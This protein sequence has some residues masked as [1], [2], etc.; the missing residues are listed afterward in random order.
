MSLRV[1]AVT[2]I[3]PNR[4]EPL[5]CAFQR[6]Q[7][8]SL[9][10]RCHVEVLATI[11]YLA[12]AS[13]LGDRT[14]PGRLRHVPEQE[15]IDGIPVIHPRVPY[16]PGT[17]RVQAMAPVNAPLYLAGLLPHVRKLRG[18]FDVVLGTFL[19]PDAWAASAVARILNLPYAIK[20]HGTDVNVIGQWSSVKPIVASTL[21]AASWVF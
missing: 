18:R 8:V 11:P 7:L 21:R 13:L 1:L 16:L 14:R 19:Y 5:A 4:V 9:S 2:R 10:R 15:E 20:T 6:Q 17:E 3:F 12:G